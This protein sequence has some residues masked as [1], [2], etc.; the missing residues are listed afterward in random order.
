MI[1]FMT[2][3]KELNVIGEGG[4][5]KNLLRG[6]L[7]NIHKL[8]LTKSN[9]DE[10]EIPVFGMD[11]LEL[12]EFSEN[13]CLSNLF[14]E[15][16][17]N[18]ESVI[19]YGSR[20][21]EAISLTGCAKLKNL[22]LSR[23]FQNLDF[24]GIAGAVVEILDLS[25]MTAPNLRVLALHDCEK[26]C[27]ILWPSPA[28]DKRNIY[29]SK[30]F[31]DTKQKEGSAADTWRP[32]SASD[33]WKRFSEET[34]FAW[35]V[36]IRDAR[37]LQSLEPVKEYYGSEDAH[38]E[39][40]TISSPTHPC[41]DAA[42]TKDGRMS[43][44]SGQHVQMK[45]KQP[46]D[47][48]I[49]ADVVV[50]LKDTSTQQQEAAANEGYSGGALGV[51]WTCPVPPKV[52]SQG[53]YIHIEDPTRRVKS[54]TASITLPG[55]ICDGAKVLHVHDCL[56]VA[57]I[58]AVPLA[59]ATWNKLEWCRV[60]RCP[61]LECVFIPQLDGPEGSNN[62][63]GM[64]KKLMTT[65]VSHLLKARY[66]WKWSGTSPSW[67]LPGDDTFDDL[68]LLHIDY[69]PRL[70]Q[71]IYSPLAF[72][73][74]NKLETLEIMWC[75]DLNV[76]FQFYNPRAPI[77]EFRRRWFFGLKH[78]HLH[79][80]PKLRNICNVGA[81]IRMPKLKNIKIRGCW[82][83]RTLPSIDPA[84]RDIVPSASIIGGENMVECDCE[85]EWW[86]RLEWVSEEHARQYKPI[87]PRHYKKTM[88]RGSVLR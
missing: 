66:I 21:L 55:F 20:D 45:L 79:E 44:S 33:Y 27:A 52:L 16:C 63:T 58:L 56:H 29:L 78:V 5:D 36:S 30:L 6:Q 49:Y 23:S 68:I 65:W 85:K 71:V 60:E 80:L 41:S 4:F 88:L 57:S 46:K 77:S 35:H 19:I 11:K 15:S 13:T 32:P 26:L 50:T 76:A 25:A 38:V 7:C 59:S 53:C 87:H 54:Q 48:A 2:H 31:I 28:E 64:F 22:F 24:I 18:L 67:S 10:H 86:D 1:N 9:M 62:H 3:L 34:N 42:G 74:F 75:C 40:S 73:S 61:K 72:K 47:N 8:R 69:C 12:F 84:I 82:S 81:R 43:S 37:I 51:K 17:N 14:I 83:L 70:I 39:I